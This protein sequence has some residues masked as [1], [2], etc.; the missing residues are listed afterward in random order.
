MAYKNRFL[1][2][3]RGPWNKS[4]GRDYTKEDKFKKTKKAKAA[5]NKR[6]KDRNKAIK[7]GRVKR[8]DGKDLHH[9]SNGKTTVMSASKNR[10]KAGEGGRKKVKNKNK[11]RRST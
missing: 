3:N 6:V 7:E 9:K 5:N 2:K 10:G 8:H 1:R 4:T 11:G